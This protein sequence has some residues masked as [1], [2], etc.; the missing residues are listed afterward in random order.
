METYI[1]ILVVCF[2]CY[3]AFALLMTLR[4]NIN[5]KHV[6]NNGKFPGHRNPPPPPDSAYQPIIDNTATPPKKL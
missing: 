2:L 6:L 5:R 3:L 4:E 1:K